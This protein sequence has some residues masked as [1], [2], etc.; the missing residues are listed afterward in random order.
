MIVL[1]RHERARLEA[2]AGGNGGSSLWARVFLLLADGASYR[3]IQRQLKCSSATIA[4]ARKN[5]GRRPYV[6]RPWTMSARIGTAVRSRALSFGVPRTSRSYRALAAHFGVSHMTIRRILVDEHPED[7]PVLFGPGATDFKDSAFRGDVTDVVAIYVSPTVS[8]ILAVA[9]YRAEP[10]RF[11]RLLGPKL[12][13]FQYR[14]P[15]PEDFSG[16]ASLV[17]HVLTPL[18]RSRLSYP[19]FIR[20]SQHWA[21][22]VMSA[23]LYGSY[24]DGRKVHRL[25]PVAQQSRLMHVEYATHAEWRT[26]AH[27]VLEQAR[28]QAMEVLPVESD[29]TG[30]I[31]KWM[32][33]ARRT[34]KTYIWEAPA[35]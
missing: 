20:R 30:R 31:L 10:E 5:R 34:G 33:T 26:F 14:P 11:L 15:S 17:P 25:F 23:T 22:G 21:R 2:N 13:R 27:A 16:L 35:E 18:R 32:A 12:R 4:R 6:P 28:K 1:R 29:M 9:R 24:G 3:E 7:L 8:A 19:S